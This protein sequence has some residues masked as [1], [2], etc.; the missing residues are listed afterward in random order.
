M[1]VHGQVQG[2]IAQGIG[3]ALP[4]HCI[5]HAGSGQFLSASFMDYAM[6]A[7]T[8]DMRVRADLLK[9]IVTLVQ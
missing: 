8:T 2:G 7:R 6:P 4:E 1:I 5:Y 3:Q 9:S